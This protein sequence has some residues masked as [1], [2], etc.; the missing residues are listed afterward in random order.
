MGIEQLK[1]MFYK[2]YKDHA[3]DENDFNCSNCFVKTALKE[4]LKRSGISVDDFCDRIVSAFINKFVLTK[5][6]N[7]TFNILLKYFYENENKTNYFEL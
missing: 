5:S 2:E 4:Y 7:A 3:E 1:K 6:C